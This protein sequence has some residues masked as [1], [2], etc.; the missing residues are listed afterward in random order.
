MTD[1]DIARG[2]DTPYL[3]HM[4]SSGHQLLLL[5]SRQGVEKQ[6][7]LCTGL[8]T[9]II[10]LREREKGGSWVLSHD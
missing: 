1:A 4:G 6:L 2:N 9:C 10:Y 5:Y 8:I 7:L 3:G